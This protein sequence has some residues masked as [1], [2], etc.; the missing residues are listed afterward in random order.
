[1]KK[2]KAVATSPATASAPTK[3]D[4]ISFLWPR[5][6]SVET[7]AHYIDA[8]PWHVEELYRSKKIVGYIQGK[9]ITFDRL[10]LDRWVSR[11]HEEAAALLSDFVNNAKEKAA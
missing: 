6:M 3:V 2:P 8:S 9:R 10:E 1:M 4:P 7:A 5:S 11:R